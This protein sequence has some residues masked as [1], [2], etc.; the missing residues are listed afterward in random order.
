MP[1]EEWLRIQGLFSLEKRLRGHLIAVYSFLMMG[2]REE[3]ILLSCVQRQDARGWL[4]AVSGE[5]QVGCCRKS[6]SLRRWSGTGTISPEKQPMAL[7]LSVC[8][9]TMLLDLWSDIRLPCVE[10]G[11]KLDPCGTLPSLDIL[12]FYNSMIQ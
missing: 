8:V 11:V 12:R 9:W 3:R 4:K 10:S 1:N 2:S 5:N 7:C 6:Y